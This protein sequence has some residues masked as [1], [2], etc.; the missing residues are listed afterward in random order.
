VFGSIVP[1]LIAWPKSPRATEH[2]S[3][4]SGNRIDS[5]I[6]PGFP[7]PTVKA[8]ITATFCGRPR[9]R[10]FS[11]VVQWSMGSMFHMTAPLFRSI[12]LI[13]SCI[14]RDEFKVNLP[15]WTIPA[16]WRLFRPRSKCFTTGTR[17]SSGSLEQTVSRLGPRTGNTN[18]I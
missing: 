15:R 8:S 2:L 17:N 3:I 9:R 16:S 13:S 12:D 11:A 1:D 6:S 7:F 4:S 5:T 14:S 18:T 10:Y